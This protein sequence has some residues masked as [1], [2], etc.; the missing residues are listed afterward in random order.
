MK[1]VLAEDHPTVFDAD[2]DLLVPALA[3]VHREIEDEIRI[4]EV[5]R[6]H[7]LPILERASQTDWQR[8]CQHSTDGSLSLAD[9]LDRANGHI[10]HHLGFIESKITQ[11][12]M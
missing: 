12:S 8:S 3:G 10:P 6:K 11:L 7:M 4:V 9:L 1:R 5:I 2:P